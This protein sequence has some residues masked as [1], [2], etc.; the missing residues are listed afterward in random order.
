MTHRGIR[1]DRSY[2]TPHVALRQAGYTLGPWV[3]SFH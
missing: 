3:F 1:D 2:E